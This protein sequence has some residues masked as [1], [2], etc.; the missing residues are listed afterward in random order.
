MLNE[1]D[2]RP[3]RWSSTNWLQYFFPFFFVPI[4]TENHPTHFDFYLSLS[5]SRAASRVQRFNTLMPVLALRRCDGHFDNDKEND[6]ATFRQKGVDADA[7]ELKSIV[8]IDFDR[9]LIGSS[10]VK[11]GKEKEL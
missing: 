2:D 3:R 4:P 10:Q 5:H 1:I 8:I 6:V 7:V 9:N 11:R